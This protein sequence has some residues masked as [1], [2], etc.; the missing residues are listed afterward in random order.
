MKLAVIA[1][2][3]LFCQAALAGASSYPPTNQDNTGIV[4]PEV[5]TGYFAVA[6]ERYYPGKTGLLICPADA[7]IDKLSCY[8][9]VPVGDLQYRVNA[10][11]N[12]ANTVPTGTQYVGFRVVSGP[13]GYRHLE[14]YYK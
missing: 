14:V 6:N 10:W 7:N 12:I 5:A 2:L 13:S 9:N 8:R 4:R 1:T 3:M 11:A